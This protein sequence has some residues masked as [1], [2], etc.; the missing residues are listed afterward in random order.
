[1]KNN[2]KTNTSKGL[3]ITDVVL[4]ASQ[5]TDS[6]TTPWSGIVSPHD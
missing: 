1:M 3:A 6:Q 5:T 2:S 4:Q